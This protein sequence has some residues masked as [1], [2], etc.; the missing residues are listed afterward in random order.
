MSARGRGGRG[1][2]SPGGRGGGG[3]GRFAR[4]EGPP[5]EIVGK[6]PTLPFGLDVSLD[7]AAK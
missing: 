7:R 2:R 5:A 3:G 6:Q 1:G 4:D